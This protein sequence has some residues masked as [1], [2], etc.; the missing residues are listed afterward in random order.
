MINLTELVDCTTCHDTG[1]IQTTYERGEHRIMF[2]EP[3]PI[4]TRPRWQGQ[5]GDTEE[6]MPY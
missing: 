5:S 4:C 6:R 2:T 1:Y 3:C